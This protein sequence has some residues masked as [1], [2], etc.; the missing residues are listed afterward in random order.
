[1]VRKQVDSMSRKN[2]RDLLTVLV[3]MILCAF[4][5]KS[6]KIWGSVIILAILGL[7]FDNMPHAGH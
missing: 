2:A 6:P 4:F 3:V 7:V 1:M 5:T